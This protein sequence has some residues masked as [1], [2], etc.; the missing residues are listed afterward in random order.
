MTARRIIVGYDRSTDAKAAARW[1]LDE[2]LRTGAAVEFL[3]A[4]EWPAWL[5]ATSTVPAPS[6]WPDGETDRAI[7]GALNEAAALAKQSHPSVPTH[8]TFVHNSAALE[9][10]GRSAGASLVVLG[11]RGHS[12]VTGLLGSVSVA[13][14]AHAK[15]PV[16][17]V[18]GEPAGEAP[19]VVGVDDSP[20]AQVALVFAVEAALARGVGL[21]VIRAWPQVTGLWEQSQIVTRVVTEQERRPFDE[22]IAGWQRKHPELTI[23]AEAVVAHPAAALAEAGRDAQLLVVGTRGR[24]AMLGMVLGSVSQ[25]VLRHSPCTVVVAHGEQ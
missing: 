3:Y 6:V 25:H 1:A 17:V 18:R 4:Y 11:C 12:G 21:R 13:V 2:A 10:I 24:G 16:V 8:V 22:L 19:V 15:C 14:S 5:P 7:Q 20:S 23:S 9:L